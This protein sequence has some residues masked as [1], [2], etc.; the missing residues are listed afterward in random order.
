MP[1]N[2]CKCSFNNR[3]TFII[4]AS[5]DGHRQSC[6]TLGIIK[7][8]LVQLLLLF[9]K[10]LLD[11]S[12]D[13]PYAF[14]LMNYLE[15]VVDQYPIRRA[16]LSVSN[17]RGIVPFA[18][19]LVDAGIEIIST[20]GTYQ[21]LTDARIKAIKVK[22]VT[23]CVE[24]MQGRVKTLHPKIHGAI[25]GLRNIH[26]QEA[27]EHQIEWIDLVVVNL[28]PFCETIAKKHQ[29][30]EA[31][32]NI[33]IGGPCMLRAAAKNMRYVH[34]VCDP[35]DY[36]D[37]AAQLPQGL[38]M[39]ARK[40]LATKA[41]MHTQRYD[42]AICQYLN[43]Q[44]PLPALLA[45]NQTALRYGENPHQSASSYRLDQEGFSILDAT[46]HQGKELSY[47]NLLDAD[48]AYSQV[49]AFDYPACVVV[50]HTQACGVAQDTT[51]TTALKKAYQADSLSAFGGIVALNG[52]L[53]EAAAEFLSDKFL[54]VIIAPEYTEAA[55]GILAQKKNLRVLDTHGQVLDS[56][57]HHRLLHNALLVQQ[58]DRSKIT[59]EDITP[60]TQKKNHQAYK[61]DIAFAWKVLKNVPSNAIVIVKDQVSISIAGG[62]VSR[63]DAMEQALKKAAGQLEGALLASDGFFPFADSI[64]LLKDTGIGLIMQP[65]GS[66]RDQEV[67]DACNALDLAMVFT[68]LRCFKH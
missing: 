48:A 62:F 24:M 21:A 35:D 56:K 26:Q 20:G 53:D 47:N 54:E 30:E 22:D 19:A 66:K 60:V 63:V 33:D 32:E 4:E 59:I 6:A 45:Q 28:Y 58:R 15:K 8:L 49:C 67:I 12:Q 9:Q 16:L 44:S 52:A 18:Q 2:P 39:Q 57:N 41:F 51:H 29:F 3:L 5:W 31:I 46:V 65:G 34:V 43:K 37:V 27:K 11:L 55:R 1:G 23:G 10:A 61:K 38:S 42:H 36:N 14:C 13:I 64:E 40:Q 7:Q 25:L 68:G 50:K 17:K